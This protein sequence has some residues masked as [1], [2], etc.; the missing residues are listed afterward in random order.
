MPSVPAPAT[1]ATTDS[2]AGHDTL[3]RHGNRWQSERDR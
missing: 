1:T 3:L 2:G